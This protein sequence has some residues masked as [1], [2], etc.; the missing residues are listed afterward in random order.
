MSSH[1]DAGVRRILEESAAVANQCGAAAFGSLVAAYAGLLED[2]CPRVLVLG[3]RPNDISQQMEA[4]SRVRF[5]RAS[6]L[7]PKMLVDADQG[8]TLVADAGLVVTR[9]TAPWRAD[10]AEMVTRHWLRALTW[11]VFLPRARDLD[12]DD[13]EE[14]AEFIRAAFRG[15]TE[16]QRELAGIWYDTDQCIH[17]LLLERSC[18]LTSVLMQLREASV[19]LQGQVAARQAE[20]TDECHR[21]SAGVAEG[22]QTYATGVRSLELLQAKVRADLN[23]IQGDAFSQLSTELRRAEA[24][25]TTFVSEAPPGQIQESISDLVGSRIRTIAQ[26]VHTQ[27]EARLAAVVDLASNQLAVVAVPADRTSEA[28]SWTESTGLG[29]DV[30]LRL[31]RAAGASEEGKRI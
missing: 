26:S 7:P 2:E 19:E 18:R 22:K 12:D 15:L 3:D 28:L 29:C 8:P 1:K 21:L 4:Q 20:W 17:A 27:A 6:A 14:V 16:G 10:E 30:E 11:H 24:D 5:C 31:G 23:Q 9:A 13:R 25:V